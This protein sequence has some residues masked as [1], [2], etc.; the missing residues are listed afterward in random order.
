MPIQFERRLAAVHTSGMELGELAQHVGDDAERALELRAVAGRGQADADRMR[1]RRA[2]DR[3]GVGRREADAASPHLLG[4]FLAPPR[5][6][7]LQPDMEAGLV[8]VVFGI[9]AT[10]A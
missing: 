1:H 8:R 2:A 5:L 9:R 10:D 6:G 4:E 7:Q 3:E